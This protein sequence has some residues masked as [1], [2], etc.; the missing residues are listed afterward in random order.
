[1]AKL[2]HTTVQVA[3]NDGSAGHT[4]FITDILSGLIQKSH[5]KKII[6]ATCGPELMEKKVLDCANK[7]NVDCEVSIERFMKCGFGVC[8]QCCVDPLGLR[9]CMEGPVVNRATANSISE[10]GNYHRD[11]SGAKIYY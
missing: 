10:F 11:K 3:T 9:M 1:M 4:G 5:G 7:N 6:L 2:P 8:G